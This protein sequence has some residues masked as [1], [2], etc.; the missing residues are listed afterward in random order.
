MRKTFKQLF[1]KVVESMQHDDPTNETL[2]KRE[3]FALSIFSAMVSKQDDP[4]INRNTHEA[5][6]RAIRIADMLLDTL[7]QK[8]NTTTQ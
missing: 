8:E 1:P 7:Q 5:C 3:Y 4:S 2:S 6:R